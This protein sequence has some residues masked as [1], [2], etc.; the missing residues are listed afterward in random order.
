MDR[1]LARLTT[2]QLRGEIVI[3]AVG[4]EVL[5]VG[6]VALAS[7]RELLITAGFGEVAERL[8][9]IAAERLRVTYVD[10]TAEAL[11]IGATVREPGSLFQGAE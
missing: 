7:A 5:S 9:P 8:T 6:P 11:I 2:G 10:G 1:H 4:G 3:L